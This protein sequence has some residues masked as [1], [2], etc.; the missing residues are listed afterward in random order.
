MSPKFEIRR[1]IFE[2]ILIWKSKCLIVILQETWIQEKAI[3]RIMSFLSDKYEWLFKLANRESVKGRAKGGQL[4]GI[5]KGHVIMNVTEW[6]YGVVLE[7]II[8]KEKWK[9][10]SIYT[11]IKFKRVEREIEPLI[12]ESIKKGEKLL[13]VCDW[14]GRIG[15]DQG[16]AYDINE[17]EWVRN[18]EDER[19][20]SITLY[21]F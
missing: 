6:E 4:V 5:K 18:S 7:G 21:Y 11:N 10:V 1:I 19:L 14:I 9:I 13:I 3:G 16:R 17:T 12:Q 2:K 20:L 15:R 8:K